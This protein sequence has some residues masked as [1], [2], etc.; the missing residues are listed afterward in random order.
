M[1]GALPAESTRLSKGH[2]QAGHD[3]CIRQHCNQCPIGP[4]GRVGCGRPQNDSPILLEGICA[5]SGNALPVA[6]SRVGT[7]RDSP[8]PGWEKIGTRATRAR[9]IVPSSVLRFQGRFDWIFA[10]PTLRNRY[11]CPLKL[12]CPIGQNDLIHPIWPGIGSGSLD[13]KF[14]PTRCTVLVDPH[15]RVQC[16]Q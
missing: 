2:S 15:C 8:K 10:F 6:S 5:M 12:V 3:R 16:V 11:I 1:G 4:A 9:W 13:V 7:V 14:D